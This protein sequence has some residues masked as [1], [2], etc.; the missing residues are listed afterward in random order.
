M[1]TIAR[2]LIEKRLIFFS[3]S[4][5][6]AVVFGLLI[7][8]VNINQDQTKYLA[9]DSDMRKGLEIINS[10]FPPVEVKDSFQ[11][12]FAN[13]TASEKTEILQKLKLYKGVDSVDY[14]DS[15]AHNTKT[16]TMY[17][18]HTEYVTD[19]NKVNSVI[20]SM[21]KDFG[22]QYTVHTYYS[23]GYM[24]VLDLLI[25]LATGIMLILLL[26][27][28]RAY[29]EP[30]L[31]LVSLG[32][33]IL[34]NMGTN[35]FFESVSDITFG[36]APVLQLV[37]SID[38]SIILLHR[39]QQEDLLLGGRNKKQAMI[40][41]VSHAMSSIASSS[42][43]TVVGLLVL[44]LMSFTIGTDIG[45]VLSKGVLLSLICVFTVMPSMILWFDDL[46]LKTNKEYI[47]QKKISNNG[48]D[49][50]A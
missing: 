41:A 36:I 39:Y 38:Y 37:L 13:L 20:N 30:V 40:N 19:N 31:L 11:I 27:M 21:K 8:S 28:C 12:M 25:P 48:G 18:V 14:D 34:I 49:D 24:D 26:I 4:V 22:D 16:Y 3:V 17:I 42:A 47:K 50:N 46:L 33:A 35:V 43:T 7:G 15:S 23:G 5:I 45:I 2:I 6:L 9:K 10:E 44:L 29:I 32:V 1:K